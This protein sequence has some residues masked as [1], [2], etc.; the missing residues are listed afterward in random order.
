MR[1][2]VRASDGRGKE[3]IL[4]KK[5]LKYL[6]LKNELDLEYWV[7]NET[8]VKERIAS[9]S[10]LVCRASES[11]DKI[12]LKILEEEAREAA[13]SVIAVMNKLNLVNK[14]FDLV[15]AGGVFSCKRFFKDK[16]INILLRENKK[17]IIKAIKGKPID[18]AIIL[19]IRNLKN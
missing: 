16:F 10:K 8:A 18:G 5:I 14:S 11:G 19:A 7:N 9:I 1:A 3:T 4:A 17:I 2:V 13:V 12:C 15:M 6:K